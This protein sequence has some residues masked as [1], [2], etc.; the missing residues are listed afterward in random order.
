VSARDQDVVWLAA[1]SGD[2]DALTTLVRAYHDRVYRF[3]LRVCRDGFDAD[4]AVQEAFSKLARRP[5]LIRDRSALSWLF[6][7]VRNACSRLLRPFARQRRSLGERVDDVDDIAH[8]QPDAQTALERW[9]LV[10]SVHSAI[11][12]LERPYRDVLVLRDLEG[13]SGADTCRAL[14]LELSLMKTRLHRARAK[15]RDALEG[16]E[17]R[18]GRAS[19]A[20]PRP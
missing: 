16:S 15:L 19:F 1:A 17:V 20:P 4:D 12:K 13:L 11:A 18:E 3:G 9:E 10:Q 8:D 6:S 7:V 2:D 5:E 14:G